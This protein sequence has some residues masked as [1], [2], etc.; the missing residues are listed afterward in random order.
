[1]EIE[2]SYELAVGQALLL[3]SM[4]TNRLNEGG[5]R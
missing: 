1:M 2:H 5:V 4:E 3:E